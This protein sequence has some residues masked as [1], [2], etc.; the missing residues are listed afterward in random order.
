MGSMA[1]PPRFS[2]PG[3]TVM[4]DAGSIEKV[5]PPNAH[6]PPAGAYRISSAMPMAEVIPAAGMFP[7]SSVTPERSRTPEARMS[8][9]DLRITVPSPAVNGVYSVISRNCAPSS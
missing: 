7:D 8:E 5:M 1:N 2:A 9:P 3:T 6:S 4:V